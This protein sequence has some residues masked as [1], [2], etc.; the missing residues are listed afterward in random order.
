MALSLSEARRRQASERRYVSGVQPGRQRVVSTASAPGSRNKHQS[1]GSVAQYLQAQRTP[2]ARSAGAQTPK[3]STDNRRASQVGTPEVPIGDENSLADDFDQEVSDATKARVEKARVFFE[4]AYE[5]R[6][7]LSHLPPIRR[8]GTDVN[9]GDPDKQSK[10]YNPLQYIRNRKLRIWDKTTIDAEAEG[11]HDVEKVRSWVNAVIESH[12]ETRHDPAQVVRLPPLAKSD[13]SSDS[14]EASQH[15]SKESQQGQGRHDHQLIRPR[16]PRSD[17]VTH[18]GDIIGDCFWLEQGMNK[19]KIQDRDNNNIYPPNTQFMFSGWRNRTPA[20]VPEGLRQPSPPPEP[21]DPMEEEAHEPLHPVSELPTFRSA[22]QH[23]FGQ[24]GSRRKRNKIKD[25]IAAADDR[26]LTKGIKVFMEDSDS[27]SSGRSSRSESPGA[28]RGRKRLRKRQKQELDISPGQLPP[29][30]PPR[31]PAP[32]DPTHASDQSLPSSKQNS[33]R[34]SVDH[35]TSLGRFLKRESHP[36]NPTPV[37]RSMTRA[38]HRRQESAFKFPGLDERPRSSGEYDSTA[39]NSPVHPRWPSIAIN[40]DSPP[41]SRS[42]SPSKRHIPSILKP[43]HR[44][45]KNESVQEKDFGDNSKRSSVAVGTGEEGLR[46]GSRDL[47]RGTSP[48]TRGESPTTKK[49]THAAV[50][51]P[52]SEHTG[53]SK[54]NTKSTAASSDHS[55]IRGIFKGGRIAEIVG[56]EVSRVGD[57]IW[58]KDAPAPYKRRDSELSG[59]SGYESDGEDE[60]VNGTVI[61]TPPGPKIRSRSSTLSST[62]SDTSPV[63]SNKSPVGSG[64]RPK[65]N[66]PNLPSFTSPFDRDRED[67]Q[68]KQAMLTP[69]TSDSHD[70]ISRLAA[71]HRSASRSP[72]LDRLAPPRLDT[73]D[74]SRSPNRLEHWNSNVS[75]AALNLTPSQSASDKLNTALTDGASPG[76]A[77][78]KSR[79]SAIDISRISTHDLDHES[80]YVTWRDIQRAGAF[81][82]S[83]AVK[84]KEICRRAD[85][86]RQMPSFMADAISNGD[87]PATDLAM[88]ARKQEHVIAARSIM[89]QI[90]EQAG[91]FDES[92]KHFTGMLAPQLHRQLQEL[93]DLVDNQMTPRVRNSA[94]EAGELSM[95]LSTTSTMAI[96]GVNEAIDQAM[97]RR[98]RG[99]VRWVRRAWYASIEY[100]VVGLLWAIWAG[101]SV[102]RVLLLIITGTTRTARWMLWLD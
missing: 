11:W 80:P 29:P 92:L 50:A 81:I 36:K 12:T 99:P 7:L 9:P 41:H 6:R 66:N 100:T 39:P 15:G 31:H 3:L 33:K 94:D 27:N 68:R 40:L 37:S 8:P 45:H 96:K 44:H 28:E 20:H 19:L 61:K 35:G 77:A 82:L 93:E 4:L 88:V 74:R 38:E 67:Q 64:G 17:W 58:K 69:P 86:P 26:G 51:P 22:H 83:S 32:V 24:G 18:P 14:R 2:S 49:D 52:A 1:I 78:V 91:N 57:F 65:Y 101:V 102:V 10:A 79:H 84:A 23:A 53:M 21:E 46:D 30:P 85:E 25:S 62:K 48:M 13:G 76:L 87:K 75:G 63:V 98:R 70:H 47:S 97:M 89:H 56:H 5:H 43:L 71:E 95:K 42:P 54:V 90:T 73:G 55:K 72:R 59:K 16:R 34:T 60:P